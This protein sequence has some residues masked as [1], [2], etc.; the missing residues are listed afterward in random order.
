MVL[1]YFIVYII[2]NMLELK[3][4]ILLFVFYLFLLSFVHLFLSYCPPGN[5]MNIF[6]VLSSF[7]VFLSISLCIALLVVSLGIKV[8]IYNLKQSQFL[9]WCKGLRT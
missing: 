3:F 8:Y 4:A 5:S 1:I 2:L 6:G 9:L 7:I